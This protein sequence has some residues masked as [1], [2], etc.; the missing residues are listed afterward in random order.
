MLNDR[1]SQEVRFKDWLM[2]ILKL[3]AAAGLTYWLIKS[4]KLDF[5]ILIQ[6]FQHPFIWIFSLMIVS[7]QILANALRWRVVLRVFS[8]HVN[9]REAVKVQWIGQFFSTVLPGAVTGDLLKINFLTTPSAKSRT[10]ILLL[11][12]LLDRLFAL[13]GLVIFVSACGA[14]YLE[15]LSKLSPQIGRFLTFIVTAFGIG[16]A[17]LAIGFIF[18]KKLQL[19]INSLLEKFFNR[20]KYAF[21]YFNPS[22][23]QLFFV[24]GISLFAQILGVFSFVVITYP[25][26]E[27]AVPVRYVLTLIPIGQLAV[28]LPISPAGFGVGHFAYSKIFELMGQ[29]NGASL[30]NVY[31]FLTSIVSLL[32]VIPFLKGNK[33]KN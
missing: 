1:V 30:F 14:F 31:W 10:K 22:L 24:V 33:L 15:D 13:S 5:K 12:V 20:G 3:I 19:L 4:N 21:D 11:S 18:R 32:G 7:L 27:K 16:I 29:S 17:L 28:V 9:I 6:S 23:Y 2:P 25:F 8:I 26:L